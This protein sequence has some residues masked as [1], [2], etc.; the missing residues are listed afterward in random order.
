M[1]SLSPKYT[2]LVDASLNYDDGL[3][4]MKTFVELNHVHVDS[5]PQQALIHN[6][7][8]S[9]ESRFPTPTNSNKPCAKI[10][11]PTL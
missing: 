6:L 8:L 10:Q 5:T 1:N 11:L 2:E 9:F 7:Q 4:Q 3:H